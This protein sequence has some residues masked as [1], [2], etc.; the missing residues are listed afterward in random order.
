MGTSRLTGWTGRAWLPQ[1]PQ[2]AAT[3][4]NYAE[5]ELI[6]GAPVQIAGARIGRNFSS[7]A[8]QVFHAQRQPTY[9]QIVG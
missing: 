1:W 9:I 4:G 6:D 8:A 7:S 2:C 3:H 5:A